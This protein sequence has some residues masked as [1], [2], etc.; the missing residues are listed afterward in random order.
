[1]EKSL[2]FSFSFLFKLLD[3]YLEA[4]HHVF[5][6]KEKTRLAQVSVSPIFF[7]KEPRLSLTLFFSALTVAGI[8]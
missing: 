2:F 4:Y 3:C 6:P 5:D 7:H 1:M 8:W